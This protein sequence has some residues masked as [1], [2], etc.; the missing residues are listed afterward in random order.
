[1]WMLQA[2]EDA[3]L[4]ADVCNEETFGEDANFGGWSFEENLAA[5]E[6]LY[7]E[8]I[9]A[10][11][12][13]A[14]SQL[15]SARWSYNRCHN[16]LKEMVKFIHVEPLCLKEALTCVVE[17]GWQSITWKGGYT[18][19]HLAAEF[20]A[21]EVMPLLVALGA[22]VFALD[23]KG[24]FPKDVA[25]AKHEMEAV[26]V[27]RN[28][29]KYQ[30]ALHC[31]LEV[32]AAKD[33]ANAQ[34]E[35]EP[36]ED[37]GH[38][39]KTKTAMTELH[40]VLQDVRRLHSALVEMVKLLQLPH[41]LFSAVM[42]SATTGLSLIAGYGWFSSVLHIAV[43]CGR[44]DVIEMLVNLGAEIDIKDSSGCTPHDLA[45]SWQ[46]WSCAWTLSKLKDKQDA[47]EAAAE[48]TM[49]APSRPPGCWKQLRP[50]PPQ[51]SPKKE[52]LEFVD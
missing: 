51:S 10:D 5:N 49:G 47:A 38:F 28:L 36:E 15:M 22:D 39:K 3:E 4:G 46:S 35:P 48:E 50:R 17:E 19:L 20:G 45:T 9:D 7:R 52:T 11:A 1:M 8:Q 44:G 25:K 26:K 43:R 29:R 34:S 16:S 12:P 2:R 42:F 14:E 18:A 21:V 24:R 27:L 37:P 23:G 40:E 33:K 30:K 41:V 13:E 32:S 6:K 31:D